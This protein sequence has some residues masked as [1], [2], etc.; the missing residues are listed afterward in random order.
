M[1]Y[2]PVSELK[3]KSDAELLQLFYKGHTN[4]IATLFAKYKRKICYHIF[5]YVRSK[6][7]TEDLYQ[8]IV[9]KALMQ[10][11][12]KKY[13]DNGKFYPWLLQIAKNQVIDYYRCNKNKKHISCVTNEDDEEV[14]I[15]DILSTE[16]I[17]NTDISKNIE[18]CETKKKHKDI[19]KKLIE[20][21]PAE[22]KEV[23]IL[24]MYYDM[25]FKEIAEYSKVS[26]NT[27]LGRM[28]YALMNLEK[29]INEQNLQRELLCG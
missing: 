1:M 7:V 6:E 24:R 10:L 28:R 16:E 2:F 25:S 21:L 15:F 29:M 22:Q 26:I 4:A 12:S 13:T 17:K 23:V 27:S 8:D 11:Q 5:N 3:K 20:Q 18:Q 19:I 9:C 14:N